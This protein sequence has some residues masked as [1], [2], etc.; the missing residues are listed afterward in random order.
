MSPTINHI[1]TRLL[2]GGTSP[3]RWPGLLVCCL[4]C[5]TGG[6]LTANGPLQLQSPDGRR[7]VAAAETRA[8]ITLDGALDEEVWREAQPAA[9]FVQA[10]P[11][12][13]QP[14]TDRR[15]SASRSNEAL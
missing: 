9:D 8:P 3:G 12:E 2:S 1:L 7:T 13:G 6:T 15:K 4:L 14:A 11:H 10:E 5:A